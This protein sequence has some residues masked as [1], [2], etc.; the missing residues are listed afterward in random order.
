LT[1]E[2]NVIIDQREPELMSVILLQ[3]G[4]NVERKQISP[5]DYV[6]SD[7]YAI[8]RK[9]INDFFSSLFSGRLFEQVER[10]KNTYRKP[11]LLL[12][13]DLSEGLQDRKNTRAFWGAL[14]RIEM[15]WEVPV[16]T[17]ANLAQSAD[18]I[19]TLSRRLA[20][21]GKKNVS[22]LQQPK[23][24]SEQDFQILAV[25]SFP[26]IGPELATRIL[27]KM[28]SVKRV[29]SSS[30]KELLEI[31]GIGKEKAERIINLLELQF[32]EED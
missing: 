4:I 18:V 21:K 26:G 9:T 19:V 16:I 7:E 31:E 14:L 30:K 11:L 32:E 20:K 29:F 15:D 2:T 12:E 1:K 25:S 27:K 13:G 22:I 3:S 17:T 10:L 23:I 6:L 8:E 5:G 24:I 28:S